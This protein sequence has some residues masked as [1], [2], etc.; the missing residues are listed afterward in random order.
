MP[1]RDVNTRGQGMGRYRATLTL[2]RCRAYIL[3]IISWGDC[4]AYL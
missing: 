1:A 2:A 4:Y 3:T